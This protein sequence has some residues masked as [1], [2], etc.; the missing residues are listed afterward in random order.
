MG[1]TDLLSG[2]HTSRFINPFFR[3]LMPEISEASLDRIQV[4]IRKT[5]HITE[6][7]ILSILLLWALR[8]PTKGGGSWKWR[9]AMLAILLAGL[10][11]LGDEY[12][13]SFVITRYPSA[14]DVGIDT[15]GSVLGMAVLWL[16]HRR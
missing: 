13:Q 3:W 4:A 1:S 11:A 15:L 12:H 6:Y 2:E 5:G 7:A 8:K 14:L 16:K 9:T 10:Y